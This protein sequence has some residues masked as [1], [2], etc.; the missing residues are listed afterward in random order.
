MAMPEFD[1]DQAIEIAEGVYWIGYYDEEASV[2]CNPYLIIDDDESIVIDPGSIPHF[3]IVS[4][5]IVSRI[6]PRQIGYIILSHQDPDLCGGLPVLEKII[7]RDDLKLVAHRKAAIYIAYYG[8]T[9][10]FFL[11]ED[12]DYRLILK[13]GRE[14]KFVFTPYAHG[15]GTIVTYDTRTKILFSGDIFGGM[16]RDWELFANESSEENVIQFSQVIFPPGD[17][18]KKNLAKIE[19]LDISM[20]APQHGSIIKREEVSKYIE[21]LKNLECGIDL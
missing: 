13:S 17:V 3:P 1:Y 12:N 2:H 19:S 15:P 21:L 20:V 11:P 5:K 10:P 4:R 14:L 16:S 6:H 18:M 9:S 7:G 8:V